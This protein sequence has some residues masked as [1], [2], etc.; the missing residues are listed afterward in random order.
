MN[1]IKVFKKIA[2]LSLQ[3][4]LEYRTN[5]FAMVVSGLLWIS[6]PLIFFKAIYLNVE[7]I[8]GWQWAEMLILVGT[9]MI[10]DAIMMFL[11]IHNM[12]MLQNDIMDGRLDLLLIKP[13]DSQ[14]YASFRTLNYTQ[15]LNVIPG[16]IVVIIGMN[17]MSNVLN[18]IN[19]LGYFLY[20]FSGM[21]I[22][23]CIWFMWTITAFWWPSIQNREGMFLST[24]IMARFPDDIYQGIIGMIFKYMFPIALVASPAAKI[25]TGK[26]DIVLGILT[27]GISIVLL[28]ITRFVWNRGLKAYNSSGN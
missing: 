26:L 18:S 10:I 5:F 15:I 14:F 6:V 12:G 22:Y 20:L 8:L 4:D 16:M 21:I 28:I 17:S 13:I 3:K 25:V 19:L 27:F 2:T 23:Y 11:M 1:K 24:I 7:N 9:Y